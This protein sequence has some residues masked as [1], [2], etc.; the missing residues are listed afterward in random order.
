[1]TIYGIPIWIWG[2]FLTFVIAMLA[3]DLGVFHRKAHVVKV[4]ES[5]I[6]T[7]IW[8]GIAFLFNAVLWIFWDKIQPTS[9][10][11]PD[12]AGMAFLAGYLVEKA[13]SIDNIFVILMIFAYFQIPEKYQH[14][15]LFWGIIGALAFRGLFIVLGAEMVK[16]FAW[17]NLL[18]G[19]FLILTGI[20]MVVV[21]DKEIDPEK[22]PIIRL[23]RRI[24][25]L[26]SE[27]DGQK[28]W[29]RINGKKLATPLFLA[30]IFV[31]ITDIIF[32]VDSIPAIFAITKE[33]FIVFTSNVFA[34]LG[35]RSL[36]FAISGLVGFFRY[37]SYGLASILVFVGGKMG[38]TYL[39]HHTTDPEY[40]FPVGVSLGIIAGLLTLSILASI[41]IKKP[42][43][44]KATADET[45]VPAT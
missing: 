4:K 28:F 37:L 40:K 8:I 43:E 11:T 24:F 29:T 30:L 20:K 42:E 35:L 45:A 25:P 23:C 12:Q 14:R 36:Y 33:P 22:N 31:E 7:A 19:G 26:T 17:T 5:L 39:V 2:A 21:K 13:L 32:A 38:Y 6:W 10:Y 44:E 15:V 16:R 9:T 3:L 34:I 18:F 41:W 1:M 27:F